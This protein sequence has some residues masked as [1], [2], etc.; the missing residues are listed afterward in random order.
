MCPLVRSVLPGQQSKG[1]RTYYIQ[2]QKNWKTL[3][4]RHE[5]IRV[6]FPNETRVTGSG[7]VPAHHRPSA[8]LSDSEEKVQAP[9]ARLGRWPRSLGASHRRGRCR[10]TCRRQPQAPRV[11]IIRWAGRST[12][13]CHRLFPSQ[14]AIEGEAGMMVH[15]ACAYW[16]SRCYAAGSV[17]VCETRFGTR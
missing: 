5:A 9:V 11:H 15:V 10:L 2:W 16:H 13:R 14:Q 17:T 7:C 6:A 3:L 8:C 1:L 12:S 4:F